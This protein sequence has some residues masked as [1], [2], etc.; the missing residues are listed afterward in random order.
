MSSSILP[1]FVFVPAAGLTS[2]GGVSLYP[3]NVSGGSGGMG[4]YSGGV[5]VYPFS[6]SGTTHG[7]VYNAAVE[8]PLFSVLGN[9][10]S[11]EGGNIVLPGVSVSGALHITPLATGGVQLF[12]LS[13]YGLGYEGQGGRGNLLI[14]SLVIQGTAYPIP[15]ASGAML[16]P[17]LGLNGSIYNTYLYQTVVTNLK[18]YAVS[19]YLNFNFTSFCEFPLGVFLAAGDEGLF[20]LYSS[21]DLDNG[22][23]IPA[24]LEFGT[25]DFGES[26]LKNCPDGYIN[27]RGDGYAEI[28]ALADEGVEYPYQT[29]DAADTVLRNYK[30]KMSKRVEG[31]NWR[32]SVKNVDGS[33]LDINEVA[34]FY[35]VLSRRIR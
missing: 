31:K 8:L 25:T 28:T 9:F 2:T 18:H 30:F 10:A 22:A 3:L 12:P 34:I 26:N 15:I 32:F 24:E 16:L 27:Y 1:G 35:D 4:R 33:D 11:T 20:R 5:S 17:L 29:T 14:P 13:V 7:G 6:V 19:N 23:L 21:A